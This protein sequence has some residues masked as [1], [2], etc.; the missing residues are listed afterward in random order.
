[1][2][3]R[4]IKFILMSLVMI[5]TTIFSQELEKG[6]LGKWRWNHENLELAHDKEAH[7]VGSFGLYY[8]FK[9]KGFT[10]K[11]S[12]LYSFSIGIVKETIDALVPYE[13]YGHSGG[14]GW[15]NADLQANLLGIGFAY[16]IDKL[17]KGKLYETD[18]FK[19][20]FNVFWGTIP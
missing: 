1:M 19:V 3:Q 10:E 5:V 16:V 8:F 18:N 9:Y 6:E 12:I 7:F 13:I 14:D 20:Y 17:W 11:E 4:I 15:S 2:K